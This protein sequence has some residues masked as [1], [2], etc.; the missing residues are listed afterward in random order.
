MTVLYTLT[1]N[2]KK[3]LRLAVMKAWEADDVE[4]ID[5]R[6]PG[7]D[8]EH[9]YNLD[10]DD[11]TIEVS[12]FIRDNNNRHAQLAEYDIKNKKFTGRT[13]PNNSLLNNEIFIKDFY[14]DDDDDE[15]E[16][17]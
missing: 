17:L 9:L 15:D 1:D 2:E 4:V 11:N 10:Q 6:E 14:R 7:L 16:L 12:V 13:R 5:E 3:E 8:G